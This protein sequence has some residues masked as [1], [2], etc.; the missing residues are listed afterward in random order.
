M[1]RPV[2]LFRAAGCSGRG[3]ARFGVDADIGRLADEAAGECRDTG[4]HDPLHR[5]DLLLDREHVAR[6]VLGQSGHLRADQAAERQDHREGQQH[7]EQHRR[8]TAEMPPA[9]QVD[10]RREQEGQQH[11]ERKRDQH[12]AAKVKPGDHDDRDGDGQ[13]AAQTGGFGRRDLGGAPVQRGGKIQHQI[14]SF[15]PVPRAVRVGPGQADR[16]APGRCS[17]LTVYPDNVPDGS[18]GR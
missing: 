10:E 13:Q 6:H 9:Q 5:I 4:Q 16:R 3:G 7:G 11:R 2:D 8:D 1:P 12:R 17:R 14:R 15:C 18:R